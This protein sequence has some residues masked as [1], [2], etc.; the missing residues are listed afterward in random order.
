MKNLLY[1]ILFLTFITVILLGF[2]IFQSNRSPKDPE[3]FDES[4]IIKDL[5]MQSILNSEVT[6][7]DIYISGNESGTLLRLYDKFED[8]CLVFRFYGETC[9][10]CIDDVITN[11]KITFPDYNQN[12]RILLVGSNINS[13]LQ[14][15]YYGKKVLQVGYESLG[16]P[17][18]EYSLPCLFYVDQT[19]IS[20]VAFIPDKAFPQ[21]TQ[22]Y[23]NFIKSKYFAIR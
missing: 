6:L 12:R 13:R 18:E 5:F 23:L 14:D 16:L 10:V 2:L 21:L 8:G 20:K 1:L 3:I 15:G 4:I 7:N 19:G 17:S 9:S 22:G 11:L